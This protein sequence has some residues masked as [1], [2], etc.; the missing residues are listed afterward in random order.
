MATDGTYD[1]L[2]KK[3]ILQIE[4]EK[5][6]LEKVLG[7]IKDLNKLPGIMFVVDPKKEAIALADRAIQLRKGIQSHD[8]DLSRLA[9]AHS[10]LATI[11][12]RAGHHDQAIRSFRQ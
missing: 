7:G 1:K 12:Q 3:E 10:N 6:K 11:Q 8:R 2:S 5:E 4:R 9:I